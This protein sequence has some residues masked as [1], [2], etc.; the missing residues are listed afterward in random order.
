MSANVTIT[1]QD[2]TIT[3]LK[4]LTIVNGNVLGECGVIDGKILGRHS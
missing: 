2:I 1:W 4:E 3:L